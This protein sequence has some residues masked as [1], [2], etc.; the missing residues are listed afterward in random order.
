MANEVQQDDAPAQSGERYLRPG[1]RGQ[2]EAG[3]RLA[4][5]LGD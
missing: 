4:D 5:Q 2:R 3:R 1:N